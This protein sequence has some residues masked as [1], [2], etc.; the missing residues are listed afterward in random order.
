[1]LRS[2]VALALIAALPMAAPAGHRLHGVVHDAKDQPVVG[3]WLEVRKVE[4]AAL[5]AS[6]FEAEP[7]ASM[8]TKE[9]GSWEFAGLDAGLWILTAVASTEPHTDAEFRELARPRAE[10]GSPSGI[11]ITRLI[12]RVEEGAHA[13]EQ[14]DVVGLA[15]GSTATTSLHG[16]LTGTFAPDKFGYEVR[17]PLVHVQHPGPGGQVTTISADPA[18]FSNVP[19][20]FSAVPDREGRF[21][22]GALEVADDTTITVNSF[23][24][25]PHDP[26]PA[27]TPFSGRFLQ[28]KDRKNGFDIPL[29]SGHVV[30]LRAMS[31]DGR[32]AAGTS[33]ENFTFTIWDEKGGEYNE[34][35]TESSLQKPL[36][37]GTY[38]ANVVQGDHASPLIAFKVGAADSPSDVPLVLQPCAPFIVHLVDQHGAPLKSTILNLGIEASADFPKPCRIRLDCEDGAFTMEGLLP[39]RYVLELGGHAKVKVKATVDLKP[40]DAPVVVTMP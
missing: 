22:F 40:G 14:L 18:D 10:G 6:D 15:M 8:R 30:T 21:E 2:L 4:H 3:A 33:D 11:A 28:F 34:E 27:T 17:I 32:T 25:D 5:T 13:V 23:P 16:R 26:G 35:Q 1:M 9:S 31:A 36:V 37:D 19:N 24:L 7:F 38:L 12:R 39:G 20:V 29:Q